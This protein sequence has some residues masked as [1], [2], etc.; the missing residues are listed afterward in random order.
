MLENNQKKELVLLKDLGMLFPTKISSNK[1][2]YGLYKCYCGNEFKAMTNSVKSKKTKSCGC[3]KNKH[4]LTNHRLYKTWAGMINRCNNPKHKAYKNYG[5]RGITV[6]DRWNN[7]AN[8]IE[9]MYPTFQEGLTLDRI[10]VNGNYEKENCRWATKEVQA[11]NTQL[12]RRDNKSGFRGVSWS[13]YHNKWLCYLAIN[14]KTKHIGLFNTSVEA[15]KAYD[16]Y[17]IDNNLEH[18][19]NF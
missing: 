19:K 5:A 15:A 4:N 7:I 8:F 18:T 1:A 14:S 9:D 13:K 16:Q 3:I 12:L 11:R 10:D 17:I 2:R 6:C